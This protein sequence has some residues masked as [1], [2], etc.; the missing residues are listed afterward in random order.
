MGRQKSPILPKIWHYFTLTQKTVVNDD[1]VL[2]VIVG[3]TA[4]SRCRFAAQ[5]C[6]SGQG[7]L[8]DA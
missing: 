1:L 2:S 8:I 5:R 4:E 7:T 6:L 3:R